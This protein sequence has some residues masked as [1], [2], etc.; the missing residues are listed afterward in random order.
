MCIRRATAAY[1][2]FC[3]SILFLLIRRASSSLEPS[4]ERP[5]RTMQLKQP[6]E[7]SASQVDLKDENKAQTPYR[8]DFGILFVPKNVQF[9]PEKPFHWGMMLNIAFGLGSMFTAANLYYCQPLLIQLADSF[10]ASYGDVSRIPTLVQAGYAVGLLFITPLGDLVRRRQLILLLVTTSTLLSIG[11]AVTSDL[12]VFEVI[13]FFVGVFSVTPQVL[14][15]LAADVAP[16]SRRGTAISVVLSGLLMG[17]LIARV[18]AGVIAEYASWRVVY[19]MAI[20]AQ[21][22]VLLGSYLIL[23]DYPSKNKHLTYWQILWSMG[24]FSVTEPKLIQACLIN[25][26]SCACFSNFWVTLTFLLGEPPYSYST[27]V[28]GLFGLIGMAG[29]AFGPFWGYLV[30]RFEPWYATLFSIFLGLVFFGVQLGAAGIHVAAVIIV[31]F[32][33]DVARQTIQISLSQ[34]IF[35]ISAEA[36]S[37]LNAVFIVA[38]A[39]HRSSHG[40]F[41][42]DQGLSRL[43][44]ASQRGAEHGLDGLPARTLAPPWTTLPEIHLVWI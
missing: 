21:A 28:I 18:L 2:F 41:S 11:L 7:T 35:S 5:A 27:L 37:R 3:T 20:G 24:K 42:R 9:D 15:P 19:Y 39:F 33:F 29:V 36:R 34:I 40:N 1:T 16:E 32:G 25:L 38:V 12:V 26:A 23:P 43:R 10:H 17:V 13:G 8:K 30:D 4:D 31:A 44:L 14:L 22:F 6:G